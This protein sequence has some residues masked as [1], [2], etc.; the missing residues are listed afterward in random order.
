MEE[1]ISR[2]YKKVSTNLCIILSATV[3]LVAT[4][5][6]AR[7]SGQLPSN[8]EENSSITIKPEKKYEPYLSDYKRSK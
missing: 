6:K 3:F 7:V 4:I 8:L 1:K 2:F 5:T